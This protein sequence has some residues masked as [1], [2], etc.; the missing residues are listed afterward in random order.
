MTDQLTDDIRTRITRQ[1]VRRLAGRRSV[2]LDLAAVSA[3]AGTDPERAR[4]SFP[5]TWDLLTAL[6]LD[7]YNAMS[8]SAEAAAARARAEDASP[9]GRWTA[10]CLGVRG[11]ALAHPD[12]YALIWGQ[13]VPGYSAPPETMAAGARTVLALLDVLRDAHASGTAVRL[14][15]APLPDG[16]RANVSALSDGLL[17]GL[18]DPVIARML[19]AWTQLHGMV[20]FEVYGHIA[21]VAADPAAFFS[22]AAAAMGTYVGL[23][24]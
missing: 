14:D 1:A 16:M 17:K 21:G 19:V 22:Y 20:A 4:E 24:G 3:A 8:D 18:P 9:V 7:A 11:W 6:V 23:P 5:G 10:I 2:D 13:P 15:D 12:E